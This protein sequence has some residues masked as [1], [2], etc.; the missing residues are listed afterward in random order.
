MNSVNNCVFVGNLTRDVEL[1]HLNSGAKV[2]N[3]GLAI[4]ESYQKGGE[5]VKNTTFLNM[6][7][8]GFKAEDAATLTKGQKVVVVCSPRTVTR[9]DGGKSEVVFRVEE[10]GVC[11]RADKQAAPTKGKTVTKKKTT[12]VEVD[13]PVSVG[14]KNDPPF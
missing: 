11:P 10:I 4:N 1:K 13:E 9:E 8:W 7:V 12:T 3:F 5:T 14:Q 2:A 6:E